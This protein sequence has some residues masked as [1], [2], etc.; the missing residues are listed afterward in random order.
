[1]LTP[2]RV[3]PMLSFG[4]TVL[5][6]LALYFLLRGWIRRRWPDLQRRINYALIG[7]LVAV[8]LYRL[9]IAIRH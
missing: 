4:E 9:M 3:A 2:C 7:S 1:M 8:V 6:L 5:V